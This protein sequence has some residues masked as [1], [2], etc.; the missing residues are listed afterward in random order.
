MRLLPARSDRD[1]SLIVASTG[2]SA[3]GDFIAFVA[4]TLLAKDMTGSG[5]GVAAVALCLWG[6]SVVLPRV[7]GVVA[8]RVES[9]RLVVAMSLVQAVAAAAIALDP[10]FA[11]VL[12]LTALLGSANA[13][14]QPAEFALV[15]AV[16]GEDRLVAANGYV[17]AAR[18][19][20]LIGGPLA[21]GVLVATGG[22]ALAMLV[23]AATFLFVAGAVGAVSARRRVEA[24]PPGSELDAARTGFRHLRGD[25]VL[26]LAIGVTT[27]GVLLMSI[28]IPAD[29]FF[30]EDDL[31]AGP[32]GYAAL[33]TA[34][35]AGMV[36]GSLVVARRVR[37]ELLLAGVLAGIVVQ[38]LGKPVGALAM[39]LPVACVGY[40][41]G[42]VGHGVRN[43]LVRTLIHHRTPDRLRGRVFASYNALR[44]G[45]ELG[46]L[47]MGGALVAA[48][49]ARPTLLIAGLGQAAIGATALLVLGRRGGR[50]PLGADAGT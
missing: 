6:P 50:E 38:G 28:S 42:G 14:S 4:L 41:L 46:A 33:G 44:N 9:V 29:P 12:L 13:V 34:W 5:F 8:D 23:D 25:G 21:G 20:G 15:P 36:A 40:L 22:T 7:A 16:A 39:S 10:S 30:A 31:G 24:D 48:A 47:G 3:A 26:A 43:V 32:A 1:L 19:A 2:V 49:G 27:A 11:L 35:G 18:Y 45:A 37:M 17:E